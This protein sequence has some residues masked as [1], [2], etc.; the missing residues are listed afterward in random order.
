MPTLRP[1]TLLLGLV[2]SVAV[3]LALLA[4]PTAAGPG[5]N[6]VTHAE[7]TAYTETGRYQ[8]V[9]DLCRGFAARY[10]TRMRCLE[11]GR[12]PEE[13]PMVALVASD[14]GLLQ[15]EA[16]R[17]A[18]QPVLLFIGG[19]H[20]GEIDG[21]D[22]GFAVLR[23]LM[24]G[25]GPAQ[26][27]NAATVLFVPVFNVDGHERF[28]PNQRPN[29]RGP[30]QAGFRTTAQN[31][32]LNRDWLK[33]D[34]PEMA[35]M[36]ALLVAWDPD[37]LVDLHVTDGAK[38]EHDVAVLIAPERSISPE[39]QRAG[40]ALR[41]RLMDRLA[42]RGHLPL[43]FYPSFRRNE[44]PASGVDVVPGGP[45][46]SHSYFGWRNRLG[47]LV[48]THSWH[49]YPHRVRTTRAVV[50]EV[51]QAAIEG[52]ASWRAA[53]R[54]GDR[55]GAAIAGKPLTLAWKTQPVARTID[56]R[57][58]ALTREP[59]PISGGTW[60]RYDERKPQV[61]RVEVFEQL[62]P[63]LTAT[64]PRAGYVVPAAQAAWVAT[65]LASHGLRFERL[66]TT[67]PRANTAVFRTDKVQFAA[68][69]FEGRVG[70]KV[71]GRWRPER[72]DIPAGSLFVPIAQPR[73]PLLLHLFEPTAPDSLVAWGFF[74][75]AF[76]QKEHMEAYV[77]EEEARKM[78]ARDPGLQKAFDAELAR[79]PALA[80]NPRG[81]LDFF[82]RRH[83]AWDE[84][85][86]LY[87]ILRVDSRP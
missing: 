55:T 85:V 9:L 46:L 24:E 54:A 38:F 36:L 41:E 26:A 75:A 69:P 28:G 83:P 21:K 13:R 20:A 6:L 44:D 60:I 71:Q 52:G 4:A 57:G 17:K 78:L 66:D 64:A 27:L 11:F 32:N 19:I 87:P 30:R 62:T 10:P 3:I 76:E 67:R 35:A 5:A 72:R 80:G 15:P 39:L 1:D 2:S 68:A 48:E 22:A 61:W 63:T 49:D 40:G 16:A 86:N 77:A 47:V 23:D 73:A 18:E 82:Y 74:H 34:A 12:T 25:R 33:A 56:F 42:K 59:S 65:R 50:E 70:A 79:D 51:L 14:A 31:L 53:S 7:R 29:Q 81:R 45:R 84:R 58:Y 43:P 37:I 8:E